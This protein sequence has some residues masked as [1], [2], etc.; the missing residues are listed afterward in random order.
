MT[1]KE[2]GCNAWI[3][4]NSRGISAEVRA[5]PIGF[6]GV[7]SRYQRG[8]VRQSQRS[9]EQKTN[10]AMGRIVE[11]Y[12]VPTRAVVFS[13]WVPRWTKSMM[14]QCKVWVS[15]EGSFLKPKP[16][17]F[18]TRS[19]LSPV[20]CMQLYA[21]TF[22]Q[23]IINVFEFVENTHIRHRKTTYKRLN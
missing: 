21:A 9:K 5:M 1:P 6:D 8:H 11:L 20:Y 12:L 14:Q 10:D 7:G 22:V 3:E 18:W 15:C 19:K 2:K 4:K 16:T 23:T 13:D 17:Y